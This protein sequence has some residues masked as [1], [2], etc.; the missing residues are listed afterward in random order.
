VGTISPSRTGVHS[1]VDDGYLTALEAQLLVLEG[2]ELVVLSAC[3]TGLGVVKTGE[4]VYGLQQ[5]QQLAGA[6]NILMSL[7]KVD[8]EAAARLMMEFYRQ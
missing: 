7:W 3:E 2:T 5:S 8:D 6:R 4:G 1:L